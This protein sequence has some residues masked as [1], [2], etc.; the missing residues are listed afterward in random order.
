MHLNNNTLLQLVNPEVPKFQPRNKQLSPFMQRE[1]RKQFV[2]E[3]NDKIRKDIL[4]QYN[5]DPINS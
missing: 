3:R 1:Q 4:K 2:Q 5:I